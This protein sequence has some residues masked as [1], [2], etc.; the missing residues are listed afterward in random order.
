MKL[1]DNTIVK[2]MDIVY[3]TEVEKVSFIFNSQ[4]PVSQKAELSIDFEGEVND[5]LKGFYRSK[6]TAIG[7]N[8]EQEERYAFVTQFEATDARRCFPCFD[9]PAMKATFDISLTMP[10]NRIAI[11]NMPV[12]SS[13]IQE[14]NLKKL[15][16][17]TSPIMSTYR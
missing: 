16:F 9:E 14:N 8:G 7:E 17:E 10:Q 5:K 12:L 3:E 1:E 2:P 6:Y 15:T 4:L 11:S 13:E